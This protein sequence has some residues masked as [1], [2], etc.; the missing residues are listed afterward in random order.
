VKA[1]EMSAFRAYL[2]GIAVERNLAMLHLDLPT[3]HLWPPIGG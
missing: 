1:L 3:S 2:A